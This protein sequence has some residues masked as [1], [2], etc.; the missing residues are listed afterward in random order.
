M[1]RIDEVRKLYLEG[2]SQHQIAA[3]LGVSQATISYDCQAI[4][5]VDESFALAMRS[6]PGQTTREV[7]LKA[8]AKLLANGSTQRDAAAAL[9]LSRRTVR[10]Y[11][12]ELVERGFDFAGDRLRDNGSV[13]ERHDRVIEL[14]AAGMT[15][16]QIA[17]ELGVSEMTISTD[18]HALGLRPLRGREIEKRHDRVIELHADG[19]T[20]TEI[21]ATLGVSKSTISRDLALLD[22]S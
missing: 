7:R 13:E 1:S 12:R 5:A 11:S 20:G 8:L 18:K 9:N 16:R 15:G 2:R 3:E 17:A 14:H 19:M 10:A 21:A 4:S 22:L 6:S